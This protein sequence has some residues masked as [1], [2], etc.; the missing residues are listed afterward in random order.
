MVFKNQADAKRKQKIPGAQWVRRLQKRNFGSW[1]SL[2][3]VVLENS[4]SFK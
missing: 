4:L 3:F 2:D 1:I